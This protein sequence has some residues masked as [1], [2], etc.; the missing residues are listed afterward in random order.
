MI[1]LNQVLED[2]SQLPDEQ[3]E[4]LIEIL[5]HRLYESRREEIARDAQQS[6]H[7]FRQGLFR[8]Q[9]AQEIMAELD[10]FLDEAGE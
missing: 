4:M 9:S 10:Q 2:A 7:D 8:P 1:T 3:Q 5:R 6:L